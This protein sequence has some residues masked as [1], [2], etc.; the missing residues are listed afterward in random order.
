M[1]LLMMAVAGVDFTAAMGLCGCVSR[2]QGVAI[3]TGDTRYRAAHDQFVQGMQDLQVGPQ[4]GI[5]G[6]AAPSH[7]QV[8]RNA[9]DEA[10]N[11]WRA[12]LQHHGVQDPAQCKGGL[13]SCLLVLPLCHSSTLTGQVLAELGGVWTSPLLT[14]KQCR[15]AQTRWGCARVVEQSALVERAAPSSQ[16]LQLVPFLSCVGTPYIGSRRVESY[17]TPYC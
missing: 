3:L 11:V 16:W 9:W 4:R 12:A 5:R 2:S 13:A 7:A 17:H 8:I 1:V 10:A 14:C 15:T 6:L